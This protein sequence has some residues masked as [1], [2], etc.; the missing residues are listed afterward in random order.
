MHLLLSIKLKVFNIAY[1]NKDYLIK[2]LS[3]IYFEDK[4]SCIKVS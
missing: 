1:A 4:Y 2:I 3:Q